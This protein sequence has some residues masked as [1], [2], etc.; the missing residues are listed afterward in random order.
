MKIRDLMAEVRIRVAAA[1]GLFE[2]VTPGHLHILE[3]V[4]VRDAKGARTAMREHLATA[5]KIQKQAVR[6]KR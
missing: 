5:L 1:P 2:R 3:C 4:A 6:E